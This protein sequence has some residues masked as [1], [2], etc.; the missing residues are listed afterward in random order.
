MADRPVNIWTVVPK[1]IRQAQKDTHNRRAK[2]L[3]DIGEA[4]C[5]SREVGTPDPT[6][7]GC[8]ESRE[9]PIRKVHT[10]DDVLRYEAERERE[11]WDWMA[12]HK[13]DG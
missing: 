9:G 8:P 1:W 4:I 6:D 10:A 13:T 5:V 12:N 11:A 7:I 3:C 2:A